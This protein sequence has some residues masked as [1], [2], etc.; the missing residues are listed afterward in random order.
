MPPWQTCNISQVST[1][2]ISITFAEN[3]KWV[4]TH[5]AHIYTLLEALQRKGKSNFSK[6]A[7]TY[8]LVLHYHNV[9]MII[10]SLYIFFFHKNVVL[11]VKKRLKNRSNPT[12]LYHDDFNCNNVEMQTQQAHIFFYFLFIHAITP[13]PKELFFIF[14]FLVIYRRIE[15]TI[16][17]YSFI[18]C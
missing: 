18:L 13:G 7:T 5:S 4:D 8:H 1:G 3:L 15:R 11:P 17:C 10:Q 12:N 16:F 9:F 6:V 14:M 2:Q